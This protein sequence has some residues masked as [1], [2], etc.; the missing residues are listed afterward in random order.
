MEAER[1]TP[2]DQWQDE[3][4]S[5]RTFFRK[6]KAGIYE[7]KYVS[8]PKG[9][10]RGG[11]QL[12][13]RLKAQ[14]QKTEI[15]NQAQASGSENLM[16]R[17]DDKKRY[18]VHRG[19]PGCHEVMLLKNDEEMERHGDSEKNLPSNNIPVSKLDSS[20]DVKLRV[21]NGNFVKQDVNSLAS[22]EDPLCCGLAEDEIGRAHV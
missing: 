2:R 4:I 13:V 16:A 8:S 14:N 17:R 21:Q 7:T 3:G 20:K 9:G 12:F 15:L 11:Q 5:R 22:V 10:G 6:L 1:R 18:R 19:E